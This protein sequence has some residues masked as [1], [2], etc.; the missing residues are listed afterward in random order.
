MNQEWQ[1][2]ETAPKDG[3]RVFLY[4]PEFGGE[5]SPNNDIDY[6][7]YFFLDGMMTDGVCGIAANITYLVITPLTG[8]HYP[9]HQ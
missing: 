1:P 7:D 9:K 8:C 5:Y 2:I 3:A 4:S 6:D